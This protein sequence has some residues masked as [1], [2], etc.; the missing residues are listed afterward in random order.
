MRSA[1]QRSHS[2]TVEFSEEPPLT[3][4][5]NKLMSIWVS[6]RDVRLILINSE[7]FSNLMVSLLKNRSSN[8]IHHIKRAKLFTEN[9]AMARLWDILRG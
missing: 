6:N 3:S 8:T 2:V 7:L 1:D 9:S 5:I 4:L